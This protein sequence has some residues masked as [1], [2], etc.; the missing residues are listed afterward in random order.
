MPEAGTLDNVEV[1]IQFEDHGSGDSMRVALYKDGSAGNNVSGATL[2]EDLGTVVTDGQAGNW[3]TATSSTNPSLT[4]SDE[5]WIAVKGSYSAGSDYIRYQSTDPSNGVFGARYLGSDEA[6]D[7][8]D[9][10]DASVSNPLNQ[11]TT[12]WHAVR[13]N[14]TAAASTGATHKLAGRGGGL[15]GPGGLAGRG[16]GLV[17]RSMEQINGI[18]RPRLWPVGLDLQG[19]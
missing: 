9:A 5:L 14:Y 13:I 17:A 19:A 15:V 11:N 2:I 3:V 1:H 16:G 8:T 10:W 4:T 18:W 12:R 6:D 7:E